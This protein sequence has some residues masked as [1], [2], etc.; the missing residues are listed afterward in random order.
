MRDVGMPPLVLAKGAE[1]GS[2]AVISCSAVEAVTVFLEVE[3]DGLE[4]AL[5]DGL[6]ALSPPTGKGEDGGAT[7]FGVCL[8]FV[9]NTISAVLTATV[10]VDDNA[11]RVDGAVWAERSTGWGIGDRFARFSWSL[12]LITLRASLRGGDT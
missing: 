11:D 8:F 3:E 6:K 4:K 5:T 12:F 1:C 7:K 9:E 2:C 10:V